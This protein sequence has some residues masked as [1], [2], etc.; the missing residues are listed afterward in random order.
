MSRDKEKK[1]TKHAP[2][3]ILDSLNLCTIQANKIKTGNGHS[4]CPHMEENGINTPL[5]KMINIES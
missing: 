2:H 3:N 4:E 1:K 5:P